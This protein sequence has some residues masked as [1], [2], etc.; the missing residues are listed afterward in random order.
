MTDIDVT[1]SDHD[2]PA[3]ESSDRRALLTKLAIGSAGAAVG[4]VALGR[5]ASAGDQGGAAVGGNAMELGI[6]NTA[7][8]P[9]ILERTPAANV[10]E[11]PSSFSVADPAPGA[12]APFPAQVG[13][14]GN[15]AVPQGVHGSTT[16][17]NGF[18]IA[19]ANLAPESGDGE[20]APRALALVSN[21]AHCFFVPG[22]SVG[23]SGGNH[24]AGELYYDADGTFWV[25]VP[26]G[27]GFKYMRLAGEP[28]VG[29]LTLLGTPQR[30]VD[31]RETGGRLAPGGSLDVDLKR[32]SSGGDTGVVADAYAAEITMTV[33]N[34]A[35]RGFFRGYARG[36]TPPPASFSNGNWVGNDL[37][38]AQNFITRIDDGFMVANI[39]GV[40]SCDVIIDVTGFY[41]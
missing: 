35:D 2:E 25:T 31:T 10:V 7:E 4:A 27:T 38:V 32:T 33:T 29:A 41:R 13:G 22:P 39:G 34:T 1:E 15:A 20:E 5:T 12:T 17:R 8:D 23:P 14:Y 37:S 9:T 40:G 24:T 19:A 28:T 6:T 3:E 18:G 21:G 11:G 26:D 36:E 30:C 16:N